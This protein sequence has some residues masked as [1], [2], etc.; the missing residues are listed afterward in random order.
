MQFF[1]EK[2]LLNTLV[3]ESDHALFDYLDELFSVLSDHLY[4]DIFKKVLQTLWIS[5]AGVKKSVFF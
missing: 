5:I 2:S 3:N 4:E 1:I